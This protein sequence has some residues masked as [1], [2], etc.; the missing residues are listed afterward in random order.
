ML[1]STEVFN[2]ILRGERK[3]GYWIDFETRKE[4]WEFIK[5]HLPDMAEFILLVNSQKDFKPPILVVGKDWLK[6]LIDTNV[7]TIKG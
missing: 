7:V 6:N 1:N 5:T 2:I 3:E 4:K